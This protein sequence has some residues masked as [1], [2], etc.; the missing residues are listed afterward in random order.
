MAAILKSDLYR[1]CCVP[2]RDLSS[3]PHPQLKVRFRT[4]RDSTEM[5]QFMAEDLALFHRLHVV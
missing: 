2:V 4:V 3:H 5:G 1:R